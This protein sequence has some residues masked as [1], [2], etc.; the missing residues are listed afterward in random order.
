MRCVLPTCLFIAVPISQ[1]VE[2]DRNFT[3]LHKETCSVSVLGLVHKRYWKGDG[4]ADYSVSLGWPL[5][6]LPTQYA[7][8]NIDPS[9]IGNTVSGSCCMLREA[10]NE[11]MVKGRGIPSSRVHNLI[12]ST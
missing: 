1:A 2:S 7:C 3:A 12:I 6:E 11:G 4:L 10:R 5:K 8:Y 9:N